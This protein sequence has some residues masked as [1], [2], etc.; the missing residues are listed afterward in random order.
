MSLETFKLLPVGGSLVLLTNKISEKLNTKDPMLMAF[1]KELNIELK[2]ENYNEHDILNFIN[3][4]ISNYII[5]KK[6]NK[7]KKELNNIEEQNIFNECLLDEKNTINIKKINNKNPKINKLKNELKKLELVEKNK[8]FN[9]FE[10]C[11]L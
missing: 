4:N 6:I 8:E 7:K 1:L 3:N 9:I 10:N 11:L 2:L 5:K